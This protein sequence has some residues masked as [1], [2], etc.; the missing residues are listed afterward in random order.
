[1]T[2]SLMLL[3]P[4]LALAFLDQVGRQ[5]LLSFSRV[6]SQEAL[7]IPEAP[8]SGSDTTTFH[9][10]T[11]EVL[12]ELTAVKGRDEPVV[13]LSPADLQISETPIQDLQ[14]SRGDKVLSP[15]LSEERGT[16]T[17]FYLVK[18]ESPQ[19][20]N[21]Q[22]GF[23]IT[24]GC[25]ERL[26]QHYQLTFRS[27]P[28]GFR[29]GYHRIAINTTRSDIKLFYRHQYYVGLPER[30]SP[31]LAVQNEMV[32]KLLIQSA[33]YYPV[34]PPS[35]SLRARM[36]ETDQANALRYAVSIDTN[37]L[38]FVTFD[39][40]VSQSGTNRRVKLDYGVCNFD[41]KGLP[42]I[43]FHGFLDEAFTSEEYARILDQ[44]FTRV[45][46]IPASA[47][48][49]MMRLMVRDRQT[50]NLGAIDI[51]YTQPARAFSNEPS[52]SSSN[53]ELEAQ[54]EID[55][56]AIKKSKKH[57]ETPGQ[58]INQN[59]NH[60]SFI[61]GVQGPVM[62]PIGSFGSIIPAPGSF[63]GDVYELPH[64]S[65]SLPDFREI[66]PIGSL[67]TSTLDV[68]DQLFS[69]TTGIPGITPR[70]NLF[71]IDYQ[72]TLWIVRPGDYN[73]QILSDD[74][75]IL[76]VDDREVINLD[77]LHSAEAAVGKVR[78]GPGHHS[79]EVQYYQGKCCAV[80]LV[81]WI[82]QPGSHSWTVLDINDYSPPFNES[83]PKRMIP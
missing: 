78:L 73:F 54:T 40:A 6:S 47:N 52:L 45:F 34:I 18:P 10:D 82:R 43:F 16:I 23:Q 7:H 79:I 49:A 60:I 61:P 72:G 31:P 77:G 59:G 4:L 17:S 19:S 81:L 57:A 35:I 58:W 32:R 26:M 76:R 74:G 42:I 2:K 71:G 13:D 48:L 28:N 3:A 25:R 30:P 38:A 83:S 46:D 64:E 12:V 8:K 15:T 11:R 37:S 14:V 36:I 5:N 70:T 63:C 20:S 41:R 1:M 80:A 29:P 67:Y 50:G 39:S 51:P 53:A 33:C 66:D 68:P 56:E 62:G 55:I 65:A 75:A 69:N 44:G 24:A 22:G 21:A 27:G 9:I